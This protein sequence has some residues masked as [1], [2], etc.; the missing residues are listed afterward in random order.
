MRRKIER[1]FDVRPVLAVAVV[2]VVVG[3][4]AC[5]GNHADV[6]QN[7]NEREEKLEEKETPLD[8]RKG[9]EADHNSPELVELTLRKDKGLLSSSSSSP[10]PMPFKGKG[11]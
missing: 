3:L 1:A 4:V 11:T 10:E 6:T 8:P 9:M 7:Q 5:G 2:S